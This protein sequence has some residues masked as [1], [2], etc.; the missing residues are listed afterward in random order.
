[1]TNSSGDQHVNIKRESHLLNKLFL[2][3]RKLILTYVTKFLL[4]WN[5]IGHPNQVLYRLNDARI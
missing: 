4:Y 3:F 5:Y 1:M 2:R